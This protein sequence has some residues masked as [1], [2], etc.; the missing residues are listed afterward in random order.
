[1]EREEHDM[2]PW[3]VKQAESSLWW[4]R[5]MTGV[6][7]FSGRAAER[8]NALGLWINGRWFCR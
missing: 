7:E 2:M 1:M 6:E 4:L 5:P 8:R 3:R